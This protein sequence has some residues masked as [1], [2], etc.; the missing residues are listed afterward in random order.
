L[1]CVGDS[2]PT[3]TLRRH[4]IKKFE[5]KKLKSL[6]DKLPLIP[7]EFRYYYP[8]LVDKDNS[9]IQP[10]EIYRK[11][12][13]T[14]GKFQKISKPN[15]KLATVNVSESSKTSLRNWINSRKS[16]KTLDIVSWSIKLMV[17]ITYNKRYFLLLCFRI[18]VT[19]KSWKVKPR[20]TQ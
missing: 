10:G 3:A 1:E 14:V 2:D 4:S 11:T 18:T 8:Q 17:H 20:T 15:K 6:Q 7:E 19:H 13:K 5:P 12:L 9:V 16:V